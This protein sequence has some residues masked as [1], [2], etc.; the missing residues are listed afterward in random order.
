MKFKINKK[1]DLKLFDKFARKLNLKSSRKRDFIID[2]FLTLNKHISIEELYNQIKTKIPGIGYSTIYRTLRL[3]VLCGLATARQFEKGITRYEP[4]HIKKH[5]DHF[6]CTR[7]GQII[8][9]HNRTIEKIQNNLAHKYH[10][11]IQNHKLEIYGIC[12]KCKKKGRRQWR[13]S[14]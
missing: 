8:E 14:I 11:L 3:L 7:C 9:F 10:F 4:V 12:Q 5:H 2:Y 13:A 6:I 1:D